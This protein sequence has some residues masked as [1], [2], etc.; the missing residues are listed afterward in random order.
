M[1]ANVIGG[2]AASTTTPAPKAKESTLKHR[3]VGNT[4]LIG[5]QSLNDIRS[6]R[7]AR[8]V[9][10]RRVAADFASYSRR[11]ASDFGRR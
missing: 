2:A 11:G 7:Q 5:N 9:A 10:A 4:T 6:V 8:L 1:L 3:K